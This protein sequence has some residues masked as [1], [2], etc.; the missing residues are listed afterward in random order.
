MTLPNSVRTRTT[1]PSNKN[2][3]KALLAGGVVIGILIAGIASWKA[4]LFEGKK[5]KKPDQPPV[6]QVSV[7]HTDE[8][9]KVVTPPKKDEPPVTTQKENKEKMTFQIRP[10]RMLLPLLI[11]RRRKR[12]KMNSRLMILLPFLQQ[13]IKRKMMLKGERSL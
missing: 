7:V 5:G 6:E 1:E 3:F 9:Q 2:K 11:Q 10:K 13:K 8:E 12:R 4:G